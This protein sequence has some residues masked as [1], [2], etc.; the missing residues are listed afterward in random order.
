MDSVSEQ[1]N[2]LARKRIAEAANP[3]CRHDITEADYV[4]ALAREIQ[5]FSDAA[6]EVR[7]HIEA[8]NWPTGPDTIHGLLASFIL[9][10]QPDPLK[11]ALDD[12]YT[13]LTGHK[14]DY[15]NR[16]KFAETLRE[17][18]AKRGLEIRPVSK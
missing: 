16:A 7:E 9:P 2:T 11:E 13:A 18:L 14:D 8:L 10:D 3:D 15:A 17:E 4:R 5:R 6:K 1:A 12:T